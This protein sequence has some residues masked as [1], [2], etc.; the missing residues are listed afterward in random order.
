MDKPSLFQYHDQVM[1]SQPA[2]RPYMFAQ[3]ATGGEL[4][5]KEILELEFEYARETA[6]QSQNDRTTVVNLYLIL[7]GG[8]GS[9]AVAALSLSDRLV[10]LPSETVALLF[11]LLGAMGVLTFFKLIRLRQAWQDSALA[12]NQIKDFYLSRFPDLSAAFRWRTETLPAPGKVGT[13]TFILASM[14]A[15]IDSVAFAAAAVLLHLRESTAG[16]LIA[17]LVFAF[18]IVFQAI[19]YYYELV[20][21][22]IK[23]ASKSTP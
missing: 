15:L 21:P 9:L 8:V 14:I 13:I 6:T 12:M 5:A 10:A 22:Q 18:A 1:S 17:L 23:A 7:V 16:L 3:V 20:W 4:H 11:A 19:V 2:P